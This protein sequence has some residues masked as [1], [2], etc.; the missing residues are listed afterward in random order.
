MKLASLAFVVVLLIAH[1]AGGPD[2]SLPLPLSMFRDGAYVN[3]GYL[4]F[5]L[6]LVICG[7]MLI[8]LGRAGRVVDAVILGFATVFL[9]LVAV[10]PST[11][12]FHILFSIVLLALLFFYYAT[13]LNG[14]G[15][16][17]MCAHL[18]L[19]ILLLVG[20]R[21]HSYG[22]WQK[23]LIIYFVLTVNVQ[24]WMLSRG[25][26]AI[27]APRRGRDGSPGR[28]VPPR[29]IYVVESAPNRSGKPDGKR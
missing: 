17:W 22:L 1:L 10:T 26:M 8:R 18:A 27:D 4:L 7:L 28:R 16:L 29:T 19:P 2:E 12:G 21:F 20:T 6:L 24:H 5:G 23:S 11:D 9:L 13:V 15:A 14:E 25:R 3:F